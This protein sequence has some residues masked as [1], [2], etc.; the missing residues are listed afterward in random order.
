MLTTT[1]RVKRERRVGSPS[2][3][4]YWAT[5]IDLIVA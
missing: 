3:G 5:M 4:L 2:P 1:R